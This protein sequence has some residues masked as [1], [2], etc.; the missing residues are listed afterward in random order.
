MTK[1]AL[2][3]Q[4]KGQLDD[5]RRLSSWLAEIPGAGAAEATRRWDKLDQRNLP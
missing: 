3:A 4:A 5:A 1:T 2:A